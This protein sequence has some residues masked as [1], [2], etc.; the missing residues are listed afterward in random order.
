MRTFHIKIDFRILQDVFKDCRY[1]LI[2][3]FD[4]DLA[5]HIDLIIIDKQIIGLFFDFA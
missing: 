1:R 2:F 3:N 4:R 5:V